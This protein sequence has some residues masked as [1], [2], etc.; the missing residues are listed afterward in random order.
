MSQVFK[1]KQERIII[2]QDDR[3]RTNNMIKDLHSHVK[4]YI[5][6]LSTK[7][8]LNIDSSSRKSIKST[9]NA[10]I[11]KLF[12][13][14]TK[15]ETENKR[16]KRIKRVY[17]VRAE[18]AFYLI[19]LD[20]K[21]RKKNT[22][23]YYLTNKYE[24]R[25]TTSKVWFTRDMF[26]AAQKNKEMR[27]IHKKHEKWKKIVMKAYF[28]ECEIYMLERKDWKFNAILK[29]WKKSEVF[30]S[31]TIST[32]DNL[33]ELTSTNSYSNNENYVSMIEEKN[34]S[35]IT[36]KIY[37]NENESKVF[38]NSSQSDSEM[39]NS[40][41][42]DDSI[43]D[44]KKNLNQRHMMTKALSIENNSFEDLAMQIQNE[45]DQK[46]SNRSNQMTF[47]THVIA[48]KQN[49]SLEILSFLISRAFNSSDQLLT[50]NSATIHHIENISTLSEDDYQSVEEWMNFENN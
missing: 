41:V 46:A 33:V 50:K 37:L 26:I 43:S 14:I 44:E 11:L 32:F 48:S 21:S 12:C 1:K 9:T 24:S 39:T 42:N 49:A 31:I 29:T 40:F 34:R 15:N 17:K 38:A 7:Y 16:W 5:E 20:K 47:I 25:I 10:N 18:N 13:E 45:E 3:L 28:K 23:D 4:F 2:Y 6:N 35:R 8:S 30:W 27:K 36:T 19:L 22:L